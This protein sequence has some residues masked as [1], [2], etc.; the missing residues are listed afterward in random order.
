M[1]DSPKVININ[2]GERFDAYIGRPSKWGNPFTHLPHLGGPLIIVESRK[3][4][5]EKYEDWIR[6]KPELIQQAKIEL[7]G[8]V[9]G[10]HCVPLRCHGEILLKIANEKN[11]E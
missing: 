6:S 7:K 9:L 11:H 8:K 4:A 2:D 1:T 5:I 3:E 10:C